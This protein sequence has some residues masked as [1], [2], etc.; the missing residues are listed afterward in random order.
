MIQSDRWHVTSDKTTAAA[1]VTDSCHAAPVASAA[2][3]ESLNCRRAFTLLELLVVISIL[4]IL[5][6]LTVP[7]IKNF[8]KSGATITGTR[9]MLDAVA[10]ARQ[11]A[12]SQRT[13]VYMVFVPTNCW[14]DTAG[15][16][17][18]PWWNNLAPALR[19]AVTNLADRQLSGYTYVAYGAVGDQP[20]QHAWHYLEP[21]RSLP[22]GTFVALRKF[23]L[24][25]TNYYTITDPIDP[26]RFFNVYGFHT[27]DTIPFP[28]EKGSNTFATRINLPYVAFNYLGQLTFDGQGLAERDECIPLASGS[29]F[30]GRNP[31][32]KACI[33]GPPVP[34]SPDVQ[35][36]PPG[37]STNLSYNI[38]HVDRLTGRAVLEFHK[39]Q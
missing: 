21:W 34:G 8:G 14:V 11:L 22:E 18:N 19:T 5:A 7:V 20:G 17:P 31:D 16:F 30:V 29:I 37:N 38:I 26:G 12:M 2:P 3:A 9:Q 23:V 13:T 15:N 35:E 28:T 10:R 27:N 1:Q 25:P 4:G 36:V 39:M 32:T 6:A 33:L 24:S